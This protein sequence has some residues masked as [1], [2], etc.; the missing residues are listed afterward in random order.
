MKGC[1]AAAPHEKCIGPVDPDA[2][3]LNKTLHLGFSDSANAQTSFR[4]S[5]ALA[6]PLGL[7][8]VCVRDTDNHPGSRLR[9]SWVMMGVRPANGLAFSGTGQAV[10]SIFQSHVDGAGGFVDDLI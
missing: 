6:T 4:G 7:R 9:A 8:A 3:T 1:G 5:V 10:T 2:S